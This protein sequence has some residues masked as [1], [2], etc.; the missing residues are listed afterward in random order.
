MSEIIEKILPEGEILYQNLF[1][2]ISEGLAICEIIPDQNGEPYDYRYLEVN[3][4][5]EKIIGISA[6]RVKGKK[7]EEIGP[8][9]PHLLEL[10]G[11]VVTTGEPV[12]FKEH[13]SESGNWFDFKVF[14]LGGKKFAFLF[15]NIIKSKK[16]EGEFKQPQSKLAQ[17]GESLTCNFMTLD[18]EWNIVYINRYAARKAGSEQEQ[19][20]GKNFWTEFPQFI[21][22]QIEENFRKTMS[23]RIST[24]FEDNTPISGSHYEIFVYPVPEGISVYSFDIT[25]RKQIENELQE[26]ERKNKALIKYAPTAI[27]ELDFLRKRFISVN[28]ATCQ[29]IGY[30]REELLEL[31]PF[32]ILDEQG[33]ITF[34]NRIDKWL[35][36]EKPDENVEYKVTVKDGH[37]IF[38]VL[39][40]T[41]TKDED[42]KPIGAIVVGHDITQRKQVEAA[43]RKSEEK[44]RALSNASP[45]AVL[46]YRGNRPLYVNPAAESIFGYT[47]DE[48]LMM[49]YGDIV[50]PDYYGIIE[51]QIRARMAGDEK[52]SHFEVKVITKTG[53][54][55]WLD[56]STNL[57]FYEGFP[58]GIISCI[59]ITERKQ[60]EMVFREYTETINRA[61]E[62]AE[63]RAAELDTIISSVAG[64]VIIY[65]N[66]GKIVRM[67]QIAR[68][69]LGYSSNDYETPY[70]VRSENLQIYK[71]DGSVYETEKLPLYRALH[72][73]VIRDEE[74]LLKRIGQGIW[75]SASLAPIFDYNNCLTGV[76]FT[77][78]DITT[79]KRKTEEMLASERNLLKI[80]LDSLAEGVIAVDGEGRIR[81]INHSASVL[82]GYQPNE[83]IGQKI[84]RIFHVLNNQTSE[85]IT[86]SAYERIADSLILVNCELREIPIAVNISPIKS[87]DNKVI[88]MVV[89]FQDITER[90]KIE[91]EL[92]KTE[93]LQSLGILAGGIA[94][95]F[96]NILAAILANIQLAMYKLSKN[97]SI[98]IYLS[99]TMDTARK[100]SDLTKQ[101]LTFSKGGAPVKKDSSLNDLI[102]DTTEFA[103]RGSKTIAEFSISNGL[104]AASVDEGQISQVFHNLIINAKQAMPKGGVIRIS[105]ENIT[106][107][108]DKL[109]NPG[110][111]VKVAV[112]DQGYGIPKEHLSKIFDPFF[113]TKKDGNG[114]GLATSYSII[115]RHNGYLEVESREG[116]GATFLIYLPALKKAVLNVESQKEIATASSSLKILL[117]DDNIQILN[118]VGE[119]LE[120][121]GHQVVLTTDGTRVIECYREAINFREPFDVVIMDLTVP[122]GLGGQEAIAQLRDL[123][124][125]I[126]AIVS[127]GYANDPIISEYER[128]GFR[129]FVIKPYR[130]DELN[131]VLNRV[132]EK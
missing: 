55:K 119:M 75:I 81:F 16:T 9:D 101:L 52:Q 61:R 35:N 73:E 10:F 3:P 27:F 95:D 67:N 83:A 24:C 85:P 30:T 4:A 43:I 49:D 123:D 12:S 47:K 13:S 79:R 132:I 18:Q 120:R 128:F 115:T 131:E 130:F 50:H 98:G 77:F 100:A 93:K 14:S 41:F 53:G 71:S 102:R 26:S 125:N 107:G 23:E 1:E 90:Q 106:I 111:Y 60:G 42:D 15:T 117:M 11:K 19:L 110:H 59:D 103:L 121:S 33:K 78:T 64:G 105:A 56:V 17:I 38:V 124:P 31:N 34:Q 80:T 96:N 29:L 104:W 74:M 70:Q 82:T 22:T 92:L 37:Q 89:V 36:G 32:D 21:G 68:D 99:N 112:K 46:V 39:S 87:S 116:E 127:S 129:G 108:E 109:F 94:H 8:T 84:N 91:Q 48:M 7:C 72:G 122:G 97:E 126:K 114:L 6:E 69:I 58:A 51:K 40:A 20:I 5:F 25:E 45:V 65:D 57:I 44:F 54:E 2:F 63:R 113:T 86:L 62:E 28:D 66:S 88:G 76:V 118:A